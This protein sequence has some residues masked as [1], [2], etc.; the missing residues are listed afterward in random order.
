MPLR[1]R[2]G[3]P[4]VYNDAALLL[5][6]TMAKLPTFV[7]PQTARA[8]QATE[9]LWRRVESD[10]GLWTS[11]AVAELLGLPGNLRRVTRLRLSGELI[12]VERRHRILYPG[13]QFDPSTHRIRSVI[14]PLIQV[15]S[16]NGFSDR[17]LVEWMYTATT[18]FR[19]ERRPVDHLEPADE[20][21]QVANAAMG[22]QW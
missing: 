5:A 9:N 13:F 10:H 20:L 17:D 4:F 22:I 12:G 21:L 19:D 6:D 11:R 16:S 1:T 2:T 18:Y 7:T 14:A 15:A 3:E 8:L